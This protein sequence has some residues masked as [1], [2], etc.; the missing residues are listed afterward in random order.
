MSSNTLVEAS[1]GSSGSSLLGMCRTRYR[2][3]GRNRRFDAAKQDYN[4]QAS[5]VEEVE[6]KG[7]EKVCRS[8]ATSGRDGGFVTAAQQRAKLATS[9]R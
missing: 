2:S 3:D 8:M 1:I 9:R 7:R 5:R 6:E 4:K